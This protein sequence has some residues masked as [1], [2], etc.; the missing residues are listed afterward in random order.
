VAVAI[1][2]GCGDKAPPPKPQ[3]P[4]IAPAVSINAVM[5]ALVDHASHVLWNV[6]KPGHAPKDN[7]E[8]AEIEHHAIQIA[9][10]G[11]TVAL[12]GT[13]KLDAGWA[14][15]PAWLRRAQALTDAALLARA[16]ARDKN[17]DALIAANGKLVEACEG[18]HKEF[19]PDL[20][21]E[22]IMHPH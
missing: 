18:C 4:P 17:L 19:K 7:A 15:T 20:P 3:A 21:T 22:G 16:A 9:A 1:M 6:E 14:A 12:G 10:A 2:A 11:T 13:G 5:V 8:W